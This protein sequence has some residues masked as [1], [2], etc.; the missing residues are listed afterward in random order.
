MK[1]LPEITPTFIESPPAID[2]TM[3]DSC[4]DSAASGEFDVATGDGSVFKTNIKVCYDTQYIYTA[5]EC[6]HPRISEAYSRRTNE[7]SPIWLDESVRLVI[8]P[9]AVPDS[10]NFHRFFVSIAG[11]KAYLPGWGWIEQDERWRTA[12]TRHDDRWIAEMAISFAMLKPVGRND[13]YWRVNFYRQV[14]PPGTQGSWACPGK[15]KV[16]IWQFGLLKQPPASPRFIT[17]RSPLVR[18]EPDNSESETINIDTVPELSPAKDIIIPQPRHM[19]RRT[20]VSSFKINETCKL[21]IGDEP[22]YSSIRATE[23]FN[24]ELSEVL[25]FT[26]PIIHASQ[27]DLGSSGLILIGQVDE[28]QAL[29]QVLEREGIKIE[30]EAAGP[31]GYILDVLPGRIV[32]VGMDDVGTFWGAQ[33]LRQLV[34]TSGEITSVAIRD[35]PKFPF[36]GVHILACKD[37]LPFCKK[38]IERVFSRFGINKLVLQTD[39]VAWDGHPELHDKT[40]AMPKEDVRE[41]IAI[42]KRYFIEVIPMVQTGGHLLWAFR[43]GENLDIAEDPEHPTC[44]CP[45]N[46]KSYELIFSVIDEA[47]E[48]FEN[49]SYLHVGRD[50]YDYFTQFPND[51]ACASVGKEELYIRDTLKIYDYV[52]KKGCRMMMWGDVMEKDEYADMID[53]LPKD[54]IIGD[55][56]FDLRETY[57]TIDYYKQHGFD[58]IGSPWFDPKNIHKFSLDGARKGILGM[59]QPT[60]NEYL[61]EKSTLEKHPNQLY[62]YVLAADW[63]WSPGWPLPEEMPYE[64][65]VVF[66]DL[67]FGRE[68]TPGHSSWFAVN[69]DK[70][71][72]ISIHDSARTFG[73][74]GQGKGN[75]LRTLPAGITNLK[76]T[77]YMLP[78]GKISKAAAILLRGPAL[79]NDFPR[80]VC[81]IHVGRTANTLHFLHTSAWSECR[82][83]QV[84]EYV[85][86]YED[87]SCERI[88][89]VYGQNISAWTDADHV[90]TCRLVWRSRTTDGRIIH[91]RSFDWENPH[92]EK[93]IKSI[94][95]ISNGSQCSPVLIAITGEVNGKK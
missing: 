56:H 4:W 74:L 47:L 46:P 91:L 76:G 17:Y 57:P 85:I 52:K 5:F 71:F 38:L 14:N 29:A 41:L 8:V 25:G 62:A 51:E 75:D 43:N 86:H 80:E 28:N 92:A 90:H 59:L 82:D 15:E 78:D 30:E 69:L 20:S 36:R 48:L 18:L 72:N 23:E 77:P 89:L 84:G 27:A 6:L 70:Y 42:A 50:D 21:V 33:S 19:R 26:L 34:R 16:D 13:D 94:D 95:F 40:N 24:N 63:N 66:R 44:Y 93:P 2:G 83:T 1:F 10:V 67:W 31:E 3:K 87:E 22:C 73:W 53:R 12:V 64:A 45:S 7:D 88:P 11:N 9:Y 68:R 65:S 81:G 35:W 39:T 79:T 49:P 60:W 54:I 58:V 32:L 37:T 55:W 61:D